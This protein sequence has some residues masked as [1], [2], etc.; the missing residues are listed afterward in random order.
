[1]T[2]IIL[3]S[4]VKR[5][6]FND[7]REDITLL[8]GIHV[9]ER[10]DLNIIRRT[11][12]RVLQSLQIIKVAK[13]ELE[14]FSFVRASLDGRSGRD[15]RKGRDS[16]AAHLRFVSRG[17]VLNLDVHLTELC[18]QL[19]I[20]LICLGTRRTLEPRDVIIVFGG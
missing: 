16:T 1:M 17:R 8:L 11:L 20:P 13:Q 7:T 19:R 6:A 3:A 15:S 9:K 4:N 14:R 12:M 5:T 2:P 18:T 10:L